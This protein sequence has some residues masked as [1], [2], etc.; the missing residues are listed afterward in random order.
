ME[1]DKGFLIMVRVETVAGSSILI[2]II[3]ICLKSEKKSLLKFNGKHKRR[4][5]TNP[6]QSTKLNNNNINN[7]NSSSS[8]NNTQECGGAY[9]EEKAFLWVIEGAEIGQ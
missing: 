9:W 5:Q 7:N 2:G 8:N 4:K 6:N 3:K 1:E